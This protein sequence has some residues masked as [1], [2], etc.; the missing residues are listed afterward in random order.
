MVI[1][2]KKKCLNIISSVR[3]GFVSLEHSV[4][5]I[6]VVFRYFPMCTAKATKNGI[7]HRHSGKHRLASLLL[8]FY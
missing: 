5:T 8:N 1:Y 6:V 3:F 4:K 2:K 7:H